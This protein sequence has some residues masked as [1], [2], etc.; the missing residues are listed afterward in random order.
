MTWKVVITVPQR[1][2][3]KKLPKTD[4][5]YI[6]L[7]LDCNTAD[8]LLEVTRDADA[9]ITNYWTHFT[10]QVIGNLT[11]CRL[12]HNLATGFEGIDVLAATEKG[13]CLTNGG[14][15][16]AEEV[17]DH[18][19][20]LI[21]DC[22]RKISRIDFYM[23]IGK[24]KGEILKLLPQILPLRGQTL[25]IIGFGRIGRLIATKAKGFGLN[26]ISFDTYVSTEL[27]VAM[28]VQQ[29]TMDE[30]LSRSDFITINT[31]ITKETH[32]II[33]SENLKKMKKTAYFINCAR[34]ELVD[35]NALQNALTTGMIAGA[36]I[37]V[38]SEEPIT[39]K[40][41]II[42]FD[43]VVIT[44]HLAYY[45]DLVYAKQWQK[46]SEHLKQIFNSQWPTWIIN[47]DVKG[48]YQKR[49]GKMN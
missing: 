21:L 31:P 6:F 24:Q 30:L 22:A 13:I 23:K 49:F 26:I 41:P 36:G 34:G 12:I 10:K 14:D 29:V 19:M 46:A 16:C 15:Y 44:P 9:I 17:S 33:N 35:E 38:V 2:E 32:H 7:G 43:N 20:G 37:D 25:G 28:G 27:F 42:M 5:E 18:V 39:V 4:F 40:N 8:E 11:K 47:P 3:M 1:D 45:S 48:L